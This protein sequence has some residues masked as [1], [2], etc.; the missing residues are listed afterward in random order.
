MLS[1]ELQNKI[2]EFFYKFWCENPFSFISLFNYNDGLDEKIDKKVIEVNAKILVDNGLILPRSTLRFNTRITY[3]G[4]FLI[5]S[6]RFTP[7][8]TFRKDILEKLH[9]QFL[10]NHENYVN[11]HHIADEVELTF[12]QIQRN[13]QMLNYMG[14]IETRKVL[15]GFQSARINAHGIKYLERPSILE[16][17]KVVMTSSYAILF[18]LESQLREF[19]KNTLI[20]EY[21]DNWWKNGVTKGVRDDVSKLKLQYNN[22]ENDI[23][24]T[25]F[26]HLRKIIMKDNNWK[27]LYEPIFKTQRRIIARLEELEPI[28]NKIAHSRLLNN[29]E[30]MK[31]EIFY[32]EITRMIYPD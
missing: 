6:K 24:Y 5:E 30:I 32:N 16:Q 21:G 9:V 13:I 7:D 29:E 17:M 10:E 8:I 3:N 22:N 15:S 19:L 23:N 20:G 28:R 26:P 11:V 4:I 27:K 31:L 25:L 14:L 1:E 18:M 12:P 2:L